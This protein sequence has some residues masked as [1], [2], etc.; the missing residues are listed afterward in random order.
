M[1]KAWESKPHFWKSTDVLLPVWTSTRGAFGRLR[2]PVHRDTAAYLWWRAPQVSHGARYRLDCVRSSRVIFY[3]QG[4]FAGLGVGASPVSN[5]N[6]NSRQSWR[7]WSSRSR[8][9]I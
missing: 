5:T 4:G 3:R 6:P 7:A 2:K 8:A 1:L 9:A